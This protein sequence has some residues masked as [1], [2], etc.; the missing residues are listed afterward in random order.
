MR[1]IGHFFS[2]TSLLERALTHTSYS[3]EH[4]LGRYA[5]NERLEYLGDAILKAVVAERL[6]ELMP[7]ANEGRL[8]KV[9]AQ[10]LSGRALA[11]V[12]RS[13]GLPQFVRLGHGEELSGGRD[14]QRNLAGVMEAVIGAV[15]LDSGFDAASDFIRR[16]LEEEVQRVIS[17]PASDYKTSLQ[18]MVQ[19]GGSSQV[20]YAT[21]AVEGPPHM[22]SFTVQAK[23]DGRPVSVGMGPS[24]RKAEQDAARQAL[25]IL[26]SSM[27]R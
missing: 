5:S 23:V 25:E 3:A 14:K 24:K 18:E 15:F 8:S 13:L 2:D 11:M 1:A 6:M 22:P 16:C 9:S 20:T 21:L 4:Q 17:T 27:K 7:D 10:V 12:A 26:S 19:A